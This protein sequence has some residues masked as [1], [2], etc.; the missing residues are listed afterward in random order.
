MA[1]RDYFKD[2]MTEEWEVLLDRPDAT[3]KR[4]FEE[5]G[6]SGERGECVLGD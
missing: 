1:D 6:E 2:E 3:I 4:K 5:A